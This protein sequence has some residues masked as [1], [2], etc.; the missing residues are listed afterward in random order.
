[1]SGMDKQ[2]VAQETKKCKWNILEN[3]N[4][5]CLTLFLLQKSGKLIFQLSWFNVLFC[6]SC[7]NTGIINK[8][9]W[10][11]A[12]CDSSGEPLVW[13]NRE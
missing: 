4:S 12:E 3:I 1:M 7:Y 11:V 8:S 2:R 13:M 9:K 5:W 10:D 6:F